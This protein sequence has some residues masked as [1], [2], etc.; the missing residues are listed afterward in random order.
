MSLPERIANSPS[1]TRARA[2]RDDLVEH[3]AARGFTLTQI[4]EKVGVKK[5]T[6]KK[7][8]KQPESIARVEQIHQEL[9][10]L[11]MRDAAS[12]GEYF[13]ALSVEAAERLKGLIRMETDDVANPVPHAVSLNAAREVLDRAPSVPRKKEDDSSKHLHIHLPERAFE[14]AQQ[15]LTDVGIDLPVEEKKDG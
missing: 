5:G 15:A 9:M 12:V 1:V 11:S 10:A 2:Y 8:L 3:L 13:D 4:A 6:V 14:N 7:I